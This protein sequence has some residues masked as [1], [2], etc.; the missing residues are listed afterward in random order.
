MGTPKDNI[1]VAKKILETNRTP[2]AIKKVYN[3]VG[4]ALE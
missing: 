3:L 1:A 2:E 4:K